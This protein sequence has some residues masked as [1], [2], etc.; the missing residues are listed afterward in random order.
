[1]N[2]LG[3]DAAILQAAI[4]ELTAAASEPATGAAR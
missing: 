3:Q 1:M 2:A 4:G